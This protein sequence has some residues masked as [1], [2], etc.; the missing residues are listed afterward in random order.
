MKK[1]FILA[2]A[3]ITGLANAAP[4]DWQLNTTATKFDG[5]SVK[6]A[7]TVFV[8]F[9]GSDTLSSFTYADVVGMA[10]VGSSTGYATSLGKVSKK[11][12]E[13]DSV[14]GLGNYAAYMT[15]EADNKTY[16]N[17]STTTYA[18]TAAD[19]TALLQEGTAL[20]ASSF[21]FTD[22]KP[23]ATMATASASSGG[24]VA[25]PEPASAALALAGLAMLIKR[26]K[27]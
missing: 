11:Y 15:Y 20:P 4:I 8:V 17:V 1:L 14:T 5:A 21:S 25:V 9:L 7:G 10:T 19:V 16:Y 27:A 3:L 2:A 18:L 12:V 22:S 24:W 13:A 6:T 26:R 23:D